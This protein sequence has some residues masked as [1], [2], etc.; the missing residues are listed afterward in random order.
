M[1]RTSDV[2]VALDVDGVLVE[3]GHDDD[4][5]DII[6]AEFDLT[7]A[8]LAPFFADHW[9]DVIVGRRPI[10]DALAAFAPTLDCERFLLRWFEESTRINHEMVDAANEWCAAGARLVLATNQEHRRASY[11]RTLLREHLEVIDIFYSADLGVG[12]P[13]A[14]FFGAAD[15]RLNGARVVFIDDVLANVE[16]AR[17]HGWHGVHY[18]HD[19]DWREQVARY[20]K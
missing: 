19:G 6:G 14:R 12:K 15:K 18:P 2:V 1:T 17:A 10:E 8:D 11:L 16:S 13:D 5:L 3:V 20:F 9:S 7:H 4:W